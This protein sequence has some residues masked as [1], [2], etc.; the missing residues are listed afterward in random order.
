MEVKLYSEDLKP[1]SRN[2]SNRFQLKISDFRPEVQEIIKKVHELG[3]RTIF[4][5]NWPGDY[6]AI[7]E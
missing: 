5:E 1:E 2:Y 4:H 7:V 3:W 6:V